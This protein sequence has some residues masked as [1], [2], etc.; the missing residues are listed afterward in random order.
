MTILTLGL[1]E[2]HAFEFVS[3]VD[4]KEACMYVLSK[5]PVDVVLMDIMLSD[6]T[7]SGLDAIIVT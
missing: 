4:S 6:P 2:I 7:A 3:C 5:T 1:G